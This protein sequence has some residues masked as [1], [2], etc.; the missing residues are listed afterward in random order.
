MI[1]H[2]RVHYKYLTSNSLLMSLPRR[3]SSFNEKSSDVLRQIEIV[4]G[5]DGLM[6]GSDS[7][8]S[9]WNKINR[10]MRQPLPNIFRAVRRNGPVEFCLGAFAG[11]KRSDEIRLD[12]IYV[13]IGTVYLRV[14]TNPVVRCPL[15]H[16]SM[17]RPF[18][19]SAK[20]N[21]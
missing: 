19:S 2:V 17:T 20:W 14:R 7:R 8:R 15:R 21:R 13:A 1:F 5:H 16:T 9:S 4:T 18:S 6:Q 11:K 10:K 3:T 12:N